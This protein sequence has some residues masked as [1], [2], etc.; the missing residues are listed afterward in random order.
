MSGS[1]RDIKAW[2][3]AIELMVEIYSSTRSF[4]REE[5]YGLANQLRRAAASVPS[6]IAEGK[7]RCTDKEFLLFLHHARGSVFEVEVQLASLAGSVT[8]LKPTSNASGPRPEKSPECS[9]ASSRP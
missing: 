8:P 6:N 1:L 4:P 2:Q 7:D 9:T 5:V 3:K